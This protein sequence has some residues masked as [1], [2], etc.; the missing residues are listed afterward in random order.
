MRVKSYNTYK[1]WSRVILSA[2]LNAAA[3]RIS[4]HSVMYMSSVIW[5][6]M[7]TIDSLV[8]SQAGFDLDTISVFPLGEQSR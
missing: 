5:K 3:Y 6:M 2:Q 7:R 8:R 4:Q 1:I